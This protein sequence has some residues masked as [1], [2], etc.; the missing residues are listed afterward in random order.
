M[1]ALQRHTEVKVIVFYQPEHVPKLQR[2]EARFT[3][4][5]KI[6]F[7]VGSE[8]VEH[9]LKDALAKARRGVSLGRGTA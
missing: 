1:A 8:T 9:A 7:P 3:L 6:A 5:R 2:L 4:F